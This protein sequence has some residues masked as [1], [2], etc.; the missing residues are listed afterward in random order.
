MIA[1]TLG[2]GRY[3]AAAVSVS[4]N[5]RSDSFSR[6]IVFLR[7]R[8]ICDTLGLQ[9]LYTPPILNTPVRGSGLVGISQSCSN[10]SNQ[11]KTRQFLTR[12]NKDN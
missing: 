12:R 4:I 1:G 11:I 2:G 10:Q 8:N 5:F 9:N 6:Q 7:G 3:A